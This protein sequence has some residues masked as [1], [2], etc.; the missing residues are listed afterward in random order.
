MRYLS[1]IL[2][3]IALL[4]VEYLSFTPKNIAIIQN[5]WDKFN[6]FVAFFT[7]TFL[8]NLG[9]SLKFKTKTI[10]LVVIAFQIEI[11]QSF[12]DFR[13]FSLLDIVADMIGVGFGIIG[14]KIYKKALNGK[15]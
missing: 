13:E 3:F 14:Y 7:L 6:H 4:G 5:S 15:I 1:K 10:I 11:V 12:L 2:F 8:L 9:F